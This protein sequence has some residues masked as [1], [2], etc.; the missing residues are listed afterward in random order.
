MANITTNSYRAHKGTYPL[1]SAAGIALALGSLFLSVYLTFNT[2]QDLVVNYLTLG[3]WAFG[4]IVLVPVVRDPNSVLGGIIGLF[5]IL[6]SLAAIAAWLFLGIPWILTVAMMMAK[7]E[8][9]LPVFLTLPVFAGLP[10]L[11]FP[12]GEE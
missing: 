9:S 12:F 2:G 5:G 11:F 7:S 6:L 1:L 3:L 4:I 10:L 8:F